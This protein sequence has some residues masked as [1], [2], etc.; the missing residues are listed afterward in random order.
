MLRGGYLNKMEFS[1]KSKIEI[2]CKSSDGRNMVVFLYLNTK[3]VDLVYHIFKSDFF[4]CSV[5]DGEMNYIVLSNE[6]QKLNFWSTAIIAEIHHKFT[7]Y[8][9]FINHKIL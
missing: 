1:S 8:I 9:C 4:C 5:K 7:K 3:N 2:Y 6:Q